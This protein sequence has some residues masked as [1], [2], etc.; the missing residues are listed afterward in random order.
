[1]VVIEHMA[2]D[3]Y[4]QGRFPR[5]EDRILVGERQTALLPACQVKG[6]D[7][8]L[9]SYLPHMPAGAAAEYL[10]YHTGDI[11]PLGLGR[12]VLYLDERPSTWERKAGEWA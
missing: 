9:F 5:P 11:R 6:N 3:F 12:K 1:M 2:Q 4:E 7:V 8:Y 10:N